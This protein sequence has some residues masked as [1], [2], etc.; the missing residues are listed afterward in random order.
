MRDDYN[1]FVDAYDI[2]AQHLIKAAEQG[3]RLDPRRHFP[4]GSFP[5]SV[6]EEIL[7]TGGGFNTDA[8][9]PR[10]SF[11]RPLPFVG[12]QLGPPPPDPPSRQLVF[13]TIDGKETIVWRGEIPSI[14]VPRRLDLEIHQDAT[15]TPTNNVPAEEV[16][17]ASRDPARDP[18]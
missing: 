11:P 6:I 2:A 8:E 14:H 1:D 18:P 12:D 10:R 16:P 13:A 9:F 4:D 3:Q 17:P 5:P 7:R 15:T